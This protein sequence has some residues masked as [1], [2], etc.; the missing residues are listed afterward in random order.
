MRVLKNLQFWYALGTVLFIGFSAFGPRHHHTQREIEACEAENS[1][2][3]Y[4]RSCTDSDEWF[5]GFSTACIVG[6]FW[7][8]VHNSLNPP[9]REEK[10]D[11]AYSNRDAFVG[12]DEQGRPDS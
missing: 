9:R 2:S 3:D 12:R 5:I 6:V 8:A 1:Y 11:D 10:S 4:Q 7:Y